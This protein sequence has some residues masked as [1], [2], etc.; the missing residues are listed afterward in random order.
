MR[1]LVS[2]FLGDEGGNASVQFV[3]VFPVVMWFFGTVFETGFIATRMVLFERGLDIA[4]RELRLGT[5]TNPDHDTLKQLVCENS[6]ILTNCERDLILEL[7]ELDLNSAYPQNQANCIDRTEEIEPTITFNPGGRNRIMFVRACMVVDPI[8]PGLG[9]TLGLQE[10][11]SGG[12]QMVSYTAFM[13][14]P[15]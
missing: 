6:T 8:F 2:T 1:N 14:E 11:S 9:I 4:S 13:N 12:L 15:A 5:L 10:D 7:V 3:I